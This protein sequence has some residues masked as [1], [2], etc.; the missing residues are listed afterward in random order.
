[1]K[2]LIIL[3]YIILT[4]CTILTNG[5][6]PCIDYQPGICSSINTYQVS[7]AFG[8]QETTDSILMTLG[9]ENI[10]LIGK[11]D[12]VC[13]QAGLNYACSQGYAHCDSLGFFLFSF[14]SFFFFFLFDFIFK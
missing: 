6:A 3:V 5:Q 4:I 2:R 1:M 11:I 10:T 8:T 9:F 7:P 12:P 13:G 14:L